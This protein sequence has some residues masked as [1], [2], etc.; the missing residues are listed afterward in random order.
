M[1]HIIMD[2][3]SVLSD[4]KIVDLQFLV[5]LGGFPEM[6][7]RLKMFF[8]LSMFDI[9]LENKGYPIFQ[10]AQDNGPAYY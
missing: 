10:I 7:P 3:R 1:I 6:T 4:L 8:K 9:Q 5:N 2:Y